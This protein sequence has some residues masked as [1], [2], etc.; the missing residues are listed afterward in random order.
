MFIF[1][2]G[3]SD[4]KIDK[5]SQS[6]PTKTIIDSIGR[7]VCVPDEPK[8]VA[9]LYTNTGHFITMLDHGDTI[10]AVSNGLK[11][12]KLLHKIVPSIADA[13]LVKVSGDINIEALLNEKVDLIFIP[14]DMYLNKEQITKLEKYKIPFVVT[15]FTSIEEH[16]QNVHMLGEIF[17]NREEAKRYIDFYNNMIEEVS[18]KTVQIPMEERIRI[19]HSLNEATNTV[20]K[21]TLAAE[22]MAIAGGIDVSLEGKL[23]KDG[24]KY[25][26]SLEEILYYN[27]EMILCNEDGVDEYIRQGQAW[28]EIDAVKNNKVY[29]LPNG[30]SRWGHSTSIETPLA[31]GWT[32][33]KLYP[34]IFEDFDIRKATLNFYEDLFEYKLSDEELDQL[35]SGKKMRLTKELK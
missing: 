30:I 23:E 31:I 15:E 24:D 20:A 8:R 22:W 9:C 18:K 27:P 33:K 32:A 16:Q 11:R 19:Y 17:N 29:L 25:F 12:D 6:G 35:M 3:C 7:E 34:N 21:N 28:K 4:I 10:V 5:K 13:T 2:S 14:K 1:L 26:T